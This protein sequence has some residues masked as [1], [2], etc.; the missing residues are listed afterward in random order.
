[1]N[2]PNVNF[3]LFI[4]I[5]SVERYIVIK[6]HLSPCAIVMGIVDSL[7]DCD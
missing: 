7:F 3:P 5:I 6:L 4:K 2:A 1:M